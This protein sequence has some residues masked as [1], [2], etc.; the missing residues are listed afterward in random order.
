MR[1]P[2]SGLVFVLALASLGA[3]AVADYF[4]VASSTRSGHGL[5]GLEAGPE[6][7]VLAWSVVMHPGERLL[8]LPEVYA[9]PLYFGS[10]DF[11]V[12]GADG[13]FALGQGREP[14][15]VYVSETGLQAGSC[16]ARGFVVFDRPD[17]APSSSA[18]SSTSPADAPAD[19]GVPMAWT[20][21]RVD[22]VWVFR[23]REGL[24]VP[25]EDLERQGFAQMLEASLYGPF[26]RSVGDVPT[27]FEERIVTWRPFL[28]AG[29]VAS[30]LA[31]AGAA[32]AW[33]LRL[34]REVPP[35]AGLG[36]ESLLRLYRAAGAFLAT[37]RD[38]L[39]GSL[40]AALLVALHVARTGDPLD[41]LLTAELAGLARGWHAPLLGALGLLYA[42]VLVAWVHALWRVQRALRRWRRRAAEPPIVL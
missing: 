7:A 28:Y 18:G 42:V 15:V 8:V 38:L 13:R 16:C 4:L 22:V 17:D 6:R 27:V 24:E 34:R 33:V 41:L 36:A 37:V 30:A 31:A 14:S 12:V 10:Y 23:Y 3:L 19:P 39:V 9:S 26:G 25:E 35:E 2:S 11:Y 1:K 29:M 21:P 20:V 40:M 5:R 32:L